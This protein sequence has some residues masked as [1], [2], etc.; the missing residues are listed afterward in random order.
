MTAALEGRKDDGV[1]IEA[2]D[3]LHVGTHGIAT[4]GYHAGLHALLDVGDEHI[5]HIAHAN[6]AVSQTQILQQLTVGGGEHHHAA[7]GAQ[8]A[9]V[10]RSAQG[11]ALERLARV[12]RVAHGDMGRRAILDHGQQRGMVEGQRVAL[13]AAACRVVSTGAEQQHASDK[14]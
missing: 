12:P 7:Q 14:A 2:H 8:H 4:I 6:N 5:L 10:I 1:G 11:E 9:I 13:W 3:L